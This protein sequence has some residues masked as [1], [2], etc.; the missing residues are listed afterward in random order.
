MAITLAAL[1]LTSGL[2]VFIETDLENSDV[3]VNAGSTTIHSIEID[4]TAN[5]AED[6]YVKLYNNLDPTV[7]TT[8]PDIIIEINNNEKR[9][10]LFPSGTIF[11]T[12]LT[13]ACVQTAGTAGTT[14]PTASLVCKVVYE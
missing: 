2:R 7:G 5:A 14:S 8:D 1:G 11:G 3:L 10:V 12:G 9:T 6:E 13:M 4:N